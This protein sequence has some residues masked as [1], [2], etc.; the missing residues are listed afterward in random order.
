MGTRQK[1]F[2]TFGLVMMLMP[3]L[4]PGK[5]IIGYYP[6]WKWQDRSSLVNP[7]SIPYHKLTIINYA[8]FVPLEDGTLVGKEPEADDYLLRGQRDSVSGEII[9]NTSLISNAHQ[10]GVKVMLSLGGWTDSG[11]FPQIAADPEKRARFAHWC[12]RHIKAYGFDGIDVDWE[13]PGYQPH[14]GTVEDKE[15]YNFLLQAIRDSLNALEKETHQ[16]YLLSAALAASATH[17][18]QIDMPFVSEILDFLNIMTYDFFGPWEPISNHNAPLFA[19]AQGE[20]SHN[21]D[22][23]FKLY[24]QEYKIP[25]EKINLGVPFYGHSYANCPGLHSPHNSTGK[26]FFSEIGGSSYVNLF[27]HRHL[28]TRHWDDRA[29]VPYLYSDSLQL[30]VSYDDPESVGLKADYVI[31][32]QARGLIIWEITHDYFEDGR[33]PLLEVIWNKFQSDGK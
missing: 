27:H 32:N 7:L 8:F 20:P 21:F 31:Q 16:Y 22:A 24:T 10:H 18:A 25:P 23:A 28:F 3:S 30:L 26:T 1:I 9:P 33:S 13:Y 15:N 29:K 14:N 2:A 19:P 11:N 6:S 5:D 4:N 12:V 17:T